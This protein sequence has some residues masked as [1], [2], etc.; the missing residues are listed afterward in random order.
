[1]NN[2]S[3]SKG[4]TDIYCLIFLGFLMS[5]SPLSAKSHSRQGKLSPQQHKLQGTVNDGTNPLP[6]VTI[7]IKKKKT[8]Q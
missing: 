4:G 6:G 8:M 1:M 2:F 7:S 5:F 3:F